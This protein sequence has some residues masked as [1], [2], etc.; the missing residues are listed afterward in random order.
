MKALGRI[1]YTVFLLS[2]LIFTKVILTP[3]LLAKTSY[4]DFY[5]V[6]TN[7]LVSDIKSQ[8]DVI[9]LDILFLIHRECLQN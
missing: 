8:K 9:T 1:S 7:S 5:Y 6:L 3:Q 2:K 4:P